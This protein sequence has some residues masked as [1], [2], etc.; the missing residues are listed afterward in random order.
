MHKIFFIL[1]QF[2]LCYSLNAEVFYYAESNCIKASYP[3]VIQLQEYSQI[4]PLNIQTWPFNKQGVN[5]YNPVLNKIDFLEIDK[6]IQQR[7]NINNVDNIA[8][9]DQGVYKPGENKEIIKKYNLSKDGS[10][11]LVTHQSFSNQI[12]VL[13][14][15]PFSA[16]SSSGSGSVCSI[17]NTLSKNE[18]WNFKLNDI[19][20]FLLS[21]LTWLNSRFILVSKYRYKRPSDF[22]IIDLESRTLKFSQLMNGVSFF[23]KDSSS[24]TLYSLTDKG[25]AINKCNIEEFTKTLIECEKL[26]VK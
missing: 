22:Y 25:I 9:F 5:Y 10:L 3:T 12:C 17:I 15:F 24:I 21:D 26:P 6:E 11:L 4:I 23:S 13:Y 16:T 19:S 8:I 7:F 20:S 14:D 2:L 1:F 18:I